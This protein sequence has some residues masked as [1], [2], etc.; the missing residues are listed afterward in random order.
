MQVTYCLGVVGFG[1]FC[2]LL[3]SSERAPTA[4]NLFNGFPPLQGS[5]GDQRCTHSVVCLAGPQDIPYLYCAFF[6]TATPLR[7]V[8]YRSKKWHYFLLVSSRRHPSGLCS[9]NPG[10]WVHGFMG[11]WVHG[12]AC[13]DFCYYANLIFTVH[14]L[15][16]P[17]REKLFMVCFAFAEV[18]D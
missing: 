2:Y 17:K 8:Y 12:L 18:R 3:G 13:Q 5:T 14:L 10:S 7:W 1:I 15:F 6:L 11:S 16:F 4:L 9:L